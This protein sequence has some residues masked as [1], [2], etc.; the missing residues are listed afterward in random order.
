MK[1]YL[2]ALCLTLSSCVAPSYATY[3]QLDKPFYSDETN[4]AFC[5][6]KTA[7]VDKFYTLLDIGYSPYSVSQLPSALYNKTEWSVARTWWQGKLGSKKET[8]DWYYE[9]CM[10]IR[11]RVIQV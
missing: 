7:L 3:L 8:T 9:S 10:I 4:K 2:M 1:N 11:S 6:E 5:K